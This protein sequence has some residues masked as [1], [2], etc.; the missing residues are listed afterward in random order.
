MNVGRGSKIFAVVFIRVPPARIQSEEI[1]REKKA[2]DP[3]LAVIAR[4]GREGLDPNKKTAKNGW[5]LHLIPHLSFL[6]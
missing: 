4:G 3:Q 2:S 6:Q 5:P 1:V